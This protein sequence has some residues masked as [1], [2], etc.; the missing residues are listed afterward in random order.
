MN[1]QVLREVCTARTTIRRRRGVANLVLRSTFVL[2]RRVLQESATYDAVPFVR[3]TESHEFMMCTGDAE[4]EAESSPRMTGRLTL[5]RVNR[6][7]HGTDRWLYLNTLAGS[8]ALFHRYLAIFV[9]GDDPRKRRN[10][11]SMYCSWSKRCCQ[12]PSDFGPLRY[13]QL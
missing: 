5:R 4:L 6:R 12:R 13:S 10:A 9:L 2:R 11:G 3:G 1:C 8:P 7:S